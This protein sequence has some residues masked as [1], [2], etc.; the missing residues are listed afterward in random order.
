MAELTWENG[1][2]AMHSLGPPRVPAKPLNSTST[3]DKPRAAGGTLESIVNQATRFPQYRGD[4]LVPWLDHHH[5]RAAAVAAAAS[6]SAAMTM[7]ALVPCSNRS[8]DRT[9]AHVMESIPVARGTCV[10]G[11]S[12]RMGSCN[13]PAGT[14]DDVEVRARGG[15]A[16][17]PLTPEY[18]SSK[19][20]QQSA[21]GCSSATFG[22]DHSGRHQQ[23]LTTTVDTTYDKDLDLGMG[24]GFTYTSSLGSPENTSSATPSRHCNTKPTTADD[25]DSVCHSRPQA[26]INFFFFFFFSHN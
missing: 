21:S 20:Q 6:S 15:A 22:K 13:G 10:V 4:E 7:D 11:C 3:W 17:V 16:R 18:W 25:H 2:L 8:D 9:T 1:Q 12:T 14:Q 19:E 5:H 24:M 26:I 23:Q